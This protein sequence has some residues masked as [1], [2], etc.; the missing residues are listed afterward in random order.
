[1]TFLQYSGYGAYVN[2]SGHGGYGRACGPPQGGSRESF[3]LGVRAE[4][5][6]GPFGPAL[7]AS[8]LRRRQLRAWLHIPSCVLSLAWRVWRRPGP[9]GVVDIMREVRGAAVFRTG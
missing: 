2:E 9:G 4:K 6:A 3:P 7:F 5:R 1:M 8:A